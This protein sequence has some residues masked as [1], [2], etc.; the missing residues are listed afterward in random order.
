MPRYQTESQECPSTRTGLRPAHHAPTVST[1]APP[2]RTV[3]NTPSAT[4]AAGTL[5]VRSC[6]GRTE[7]DAL[8]VAVMNPV[9]PALRAYAHPDEESLGHPKAHHLPAG[10]NAPGISGE[11]SPPRR[12]PPDER[13]AQSRRRRSAASSRTSVFLQKAQRTWVAPAAWWS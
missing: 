8:P 5:P 4:R 1:S 12:R 11:I 10:V 9:F 3:V 7:T 2:A 6:C 13:P